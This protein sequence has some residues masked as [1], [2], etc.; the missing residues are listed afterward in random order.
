MLAMEAPEEADDEAAR[1]E[2]DDER[3]HE[4]D[5]QV[6]GGAAR[7]GRVHGRVGHW[8]IA[9][10]EREHTSISPTDVIAWRESENDSCLSAAAI[11]QQHEHQHQQA[12]RGQH[13]C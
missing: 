7:F 4:R 11:A 12:R 1:D 8:R 13:V 3:E 2:H 6:D 9:A 10:C 5:D